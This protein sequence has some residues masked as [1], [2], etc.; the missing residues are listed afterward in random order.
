MKSYKKREAH[1]L[2]KST[3]FDQED[4]EKQ[5]LD[6]QGENLKLAERLQA[7]KG[8]FGSPSKPRRKPHVFKEAALK[9]Q[10][11]KLKSENKRL[12]EA[13]ETHKDREDEY[14][15]KLEEKENEAKTPPASVLYAIP[16]SPRGTVKWSVQSSNP[17]NAIPKSPELDA[18]RAAAFFGE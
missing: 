4:L 7:Y 3:I 15:Q 11:D 9:N 12:E 2:R 6:L 13:V 14:R 16:C 10:I 1:W 8:S 17:Q 18:V 5:V